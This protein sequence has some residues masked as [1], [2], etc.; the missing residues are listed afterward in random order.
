MEQKANVSAFTRLNKI[1]IVIGIV[2]ASS[3]VSSY[4]FSQ[5]MMK[6][7]IHQNVLI[8]NNSKAY[9]FWANPPAK[10]LRKYYLFSIQ[11][12]AEVQSG[13]EKPNLKEMGPYV[14]S[15]VW[16]KK[17]VEFLGTEFLRFIPV[18]TL[19]YEPELSTG[20]LNDS[21][22]FINVPALGLIETSM[23]LNSKVIAPELVNL[24]LKALNTK[25]FVTKTVG[26][27]ISGY[28][29]PLM[30]LAKRFLPKLIT[31]DEFS[32]INGK[33]GTMWQ[34]Y[35]IMSGYDEA[36]NV[37]KIVSWD[38]KERLDIYESEGANSLNGTDGTFY[39][40]FR[41]RDEVLYAY[42]ADMCRSYKLVYLK[43]SVTNG[44]DTYTF[45]LPEHIFYNGSYDPDNAGFCTKNCLP[46]GV[47]NISKC[48]GDVSGFIS[49]PHFLNADPSFVDAFV[50]LKPNASLH[51]FFL[52]FE[53]TSGVPIEGNIRFQIS[54][55]AFQ[56]DKI[57]LVK[58]LKPTLFPMVWFDD[59]LL[60][61]DDTRNQL[62]Q[63]V[64]IVQLTNII[65]IVLLALG[66]FM[67]VVSIFIVIRRHCKNRKQKGDANENTYLINSSVDDKDS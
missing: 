18:V 34:N 16:E 59:T 9:G 60:L 31:S 38:G 56:N 33:N 4:F 20:T 5:S 61:D 40:P 52:H 43:D 63:V 53:P 30:S 36:A 28:K 11:N 15:E 44:V 41:T 46:N 8:Q 24:M 29:D 64:L 27:L 47:M 2:L 66:A 13:K 3:A 6:N 26:E 58:H 39:S 49:Q 51:D 54:F 62:K 35:T 55:Y 12:P 48:Y 32:I 65:P 50:G 19:H 25:L 45:H 21:I 1:S 67:V 23:H 42:N 7:Q 10:I 17:N 37:A 57:D 14:Y 22:T